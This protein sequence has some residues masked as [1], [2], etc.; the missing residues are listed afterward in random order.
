[1]D[2]VIKGPWPEENHLQQH[3]KMFDNLVT[4]LSDCEDVVKDNLPKDPN[5]NTDWSGISVAYILQYAMINTQKLTHTHEVQDV[6]SMDTKEV[7]I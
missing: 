4:L 7:P 3:Q 2:K 1:M 6:T 5:N